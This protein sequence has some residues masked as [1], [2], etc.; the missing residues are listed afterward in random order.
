MSCRERIAGLFTAIVITVLLSGTREV[1]ADTQVI[2][3]ISVS[4]R[5]DSNVFFGF[6]GPGVQPDDFVTNVSPQLR[7]EH[8]GRDMDAAVNGGVTG[9]AY[10]KHPALNYIGVNGLLSLNLDNTVKRLLPR[11]ALQISDSVTY[12]PQPPAFVAPQLE[13]PE[14]SFARGQQSFRVN[15]ITNNGSVNASY[16][17]LPNATLQAGYSH[18]MIRFGRSFATSP[19][20][21][22]FDTTT[23]SISAGA[24]V[25]VTPLDTLNLSYQ[26]TDA[27]VGPSSFQTHGA[28]VGWSRVLTSQFKANATAGATIIKPG[29]FLTYV[30]SVSLIWNYRNTDTTV[31]YSRAVAPSFLISAVPIIS[32]VVSLSISHRF[33]ERLTATGSGNY[34]HS[35]DTS[36]TLVFDSYVASLNLS[37]AISRI[38]ST[39]AGYSYSN[40]VSRSGNAEFAFDRHLATISL[41]AEWK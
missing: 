15:S 12:T 10:I 8:K 23:Q 9:E 16:M 21:G 4:E 26:H 35:A 20:G 28:T 2:P 25:G 37:Y 3:S 36:S 29:D 34:G 13:G 41:R 38:L 17:L 7:V 39:T 6:A 14:N 11:A 27:E 22:V 32:Q 19:L 33:T 40:F 18:S 31:R 5:Y 30:S 1:S 24:A